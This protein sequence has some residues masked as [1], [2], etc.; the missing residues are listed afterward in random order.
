[1]ENATKALIIA[2]S[3]LVAIL[4]IAFGMRIFNSAGET[5]NAG[6]STMEA[7]AITQFNSQFAGFNGKILSVSKV[8]DLIQKVQSS[9]AVNG[10]TH[11]VVFNPT[12]VEGKKYK[13]TIDNTCYT[14]GYITKIIAEQQ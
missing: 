14:N 12:L 10:P 7:A 11:T 3:I 13:I 4:L 2:G 9:N 8:N 1:M 6:K 5:A